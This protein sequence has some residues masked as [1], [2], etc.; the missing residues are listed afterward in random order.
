MDSLVRR[1]FQ[2]DVD[3]SHGMAPCR[4]RSGQRRRVSPSY[5]KWQRITSTPGTVGSEA[6]CRPFDTTNVL[7]V[8][9]GHCVGLEDIV[10]KRLGSKRVWVSGR[11]AETSQVRGLL[12][13][14]LP[15]D[16][17]KFG[18]SPGDH[19]TKLCP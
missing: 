5:D 6:T 10:G 13:H 15:E 17:E 9:G 16:L 11:W 3:L 12:R 18:L 2:K 19:R 8:C 7:F 1:W 4:S 14:V